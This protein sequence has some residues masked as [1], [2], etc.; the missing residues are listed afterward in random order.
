MAKM[1]YRNNINNPEKESCVIKSKTG[2]KCQFQKKK[3]NK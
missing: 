1:D 2:K 3:K